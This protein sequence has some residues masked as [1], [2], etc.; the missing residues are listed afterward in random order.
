MLSF[1]VDGTVDDARSF[2]RSV[3]VA[4]SATSLGGTE[5]LV[6]MP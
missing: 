2:V 4:T 5:T 3:K 6:F 1:V